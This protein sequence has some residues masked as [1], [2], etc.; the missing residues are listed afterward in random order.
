MEGRL[1]LYPYQRTGVRFLMARE[2]AYLADK[3]GLGKTAQAVVAARKLRLKHTVVICPAAATEGW[4]REWR[5]WRNRHK[6]SVLSYSK[7]VWHEHRLKSLTPDLVILDEAHYCKSPSAKRTK[8]AMKLAQRAGRAWLLSGTPMPND[9]TEMWPPTKYLWPEL[10]ERAGVKNLH[11]WRETF[12]WCRSTPYGPKPYAVRNGKLFRSLWEGHML[13]RHL[14]DVGLELPPL[15]IHEE[16]LPKD[17]ALARAL[18]DYE[19]EEAKGEDAYTST[20]RRL[21]GTAKAPIIARRIVEEL[22]DGA[23]DQIVVLY[24]HTD[25]GTALREAFAEA[26]HRTVG[27]DGSTP[28]S[29]RHAAIDAFQRGDAPVFLAQQVSAGTAIT[30]TAAS[31]IVL[32]EPAWSPDDNEQAIKRIHRIGQ[33]AP[34]RARIFSV[35]GTLDEAIMRALAQ[36]LRMKAE[37]GLT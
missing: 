18:A 4:R 22:D 7:L 3:M 26:G 29:E 14:A 8:A 9:P 32:V 28:E 11:E 31:E 24:Y 16:V 27:F 21:L 19:S 30:L 15:R 5:L 33:D 36:K 34:C 37:V 17:D 10:A 6:L 35:G 1:K 13:R 2:R 20:L 12:T 23:Y 25:A